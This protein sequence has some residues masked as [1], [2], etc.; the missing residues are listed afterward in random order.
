MV[1]EVE[2]TLVTGKPLA[3]AFELDRDDVVFAVIMDA[4]GVLVDIDANNI[5]LSNLHCFGTEP[6]LGQRPR[7]WAEQDQQRRDRPTTNHKNEAGV[8]RPGLLTQVSN[9]FRA[10]KTADAGGAINESYRRGSS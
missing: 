7:S 6:Q 5:C 10:K 2:M 1:S 9:H 8:E 4:P 3:A